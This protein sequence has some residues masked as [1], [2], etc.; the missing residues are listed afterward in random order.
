[1]ARIEGQI[2]IDAAP[3]AVYH[4][5]TDDGRLRV[6]FAEHA[7]IDLESGRY[8]LWG[9]YTLGN[10]GSPATRLIAYEPERRLSYGWRLDG[11]D[12]EV[13]IEL[14]ADGGGTLLS[15]EHRNVADERPLIVE[16]FW[17][18]AAEN[19]RAYLERGRPGLRFDYAAVPE[20]DVEFSIEIEASPETVFEALIEPSQVERY[21]TREHVT[22]EP[23]VGGRY[24]IGWGDHGPVKILDLT[25]GERLSY[26]WSAMDHGI[27]ETMVSWQLQDS[28]GRTRLTLIHSGFAPDRVGLDF[29]MGWFDYLNRIKQMSEV[30]DS[31][32]RP[33]VRVT[34]DRDIR[35][36]G[37][38]APAA[39]IHDAVAGSPSRVRR[40]RPR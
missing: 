2:R 30:G 19:L 5:L 28:T 25:H 14:I 36:E 22:I 7:Q 6:W 38:Y 9:R 32:R 18:M 10:P 24:D 13:A 23:E 29:G 20:G 17:S 39:G 40:E 12:T 33:T 37:F 21:M 31:W 27:G 4:A 8:E 1:M 16:T 34:D 35:N 26:S 3:S 15:L 11:R